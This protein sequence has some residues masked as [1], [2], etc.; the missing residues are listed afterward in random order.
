MA[1]RQYE[2][3]EIIPFL[4]PDSQS[5]SEFQITARS[6]RPCGAKQI[7][8]LSR[9]LDTLGGHANHCVKKRR[10]CDVSRAFCI[11]YGDV[12]HAAKGFSGV[13]W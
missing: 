1:R 11:D 4:M 6:Q 7:D 12:E 8:V 5:P 13:K 3:S 10:Q 2:E 9:G